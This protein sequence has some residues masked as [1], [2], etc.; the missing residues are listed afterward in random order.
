VTTLREA[1]NQMLD[2][3]LSLVL[4]AYNE[5]E[6]IQAVVERAGSVLPEVRDH[7]RR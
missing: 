4:P 2:G 6:N 3:K 7:R 5:A 1:R